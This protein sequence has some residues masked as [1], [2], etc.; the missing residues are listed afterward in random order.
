[1]KA[2]N[3]LRRAGFTRADIAEHIGTTATAV[4]MYERG[5]RFPSRESFEKL[6]GLS[7]RFGITLLAN[8]FVR[9]LPLK[10]RRTPRAGR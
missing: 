7:D 4:G 5:D 2:I 1:M 3:R 6:V 9:E 8:D 10:P